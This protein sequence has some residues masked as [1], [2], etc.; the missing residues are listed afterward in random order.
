MAESRELL[1]ISCNRFPGIDRN[2]HPSLA[3]HTRAACAAPL[4][5]D[6][7]VNIAYSS[8]AFNLLADIVRVVSDEPLPEYLSAHVFGRL[9]MT[10]T[11]LG[12]ASERQPARETAMNRAIP[13]E[14]AFL[15]RGSIAIRKEVRRGAGQA[16]GGGGYSVFGHNSEWWRTL[17][18]AWAGLLT[19]SADLTKLMQA[20]LSGGGGILAEQ[21][22]QEMTRSHTHGPDA[23]IRTLPSQVRQGPIWDG[24]APISFGLS[25]RTNGAWAPPEAERSF[26]ERNGRQLFGH[27]GGSGC[28]MW[29]DPRTG[30]SF[31]M[32]TT[33]PTMC[34]SPEFGELSEL[35]LEAAAGLLG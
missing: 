12:L 3:A 8:P 32:L 27:H 26:G 4:L 28:Q 16:E 24:L 17:G 9:G 19:T 18:A 5:F 1:R 7:G 29:G 2:T 13:D 23:S 31:V 25:F 21:T 6:P 30:V 22:V 14:P 35:A 15:N 20:L 10:D 11:T 34:K 33:E